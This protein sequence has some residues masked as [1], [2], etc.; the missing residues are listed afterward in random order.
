MHG[1]PLSKM[2]NFWGPENRQGKAWLFMGG[3]GHEN[4]GG[5]FALFLDIAGT[6]EY[7]EPGGEDVL[8]ERFSGI[9][10]HLGLLENDDGTRLRV[11]TPLIHYFDKEQGFFDARTCRTSLDDFLLK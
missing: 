11:S 9:L 10:I 7:G 8:P 4:N 5:H 3:R 2:S 1:A 6:S